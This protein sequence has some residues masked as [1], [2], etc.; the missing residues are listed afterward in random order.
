MIKK[1]FILIICTISLL[2]ITA[3]G[4]E[5]QVNEDL[6]TFGQAVSEIHKKPAMLELL[7]TFAAEEPYE[8][9]VESALLENE[10]GIQTLT[11]L[12]LSTEEVDVLRNDYVTGI[13]D[14]QEIAK[15]LE[16]NT[17]LAD[18]SI[19]KQENISRLL[20]SANEKQDGTMKKLLKS[21]MT[22]YIDE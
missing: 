5:D 20:E 19:E 1:R 12:Q 3:C 16:K 10:Q 15:I 17:S 11:D 22:E 13:E 6:E 2:L 8:D 7:H 21:V 14:F 4:K 9:K 18:L